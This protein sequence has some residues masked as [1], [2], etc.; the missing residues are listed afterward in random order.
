[1][2]RSRLSNEI[3]QRIR[4]AVQKSGSGKL[5]IDG[6]L[7]ALLLAGSQSVSRREIERLWDLIP[8]LFVGMEAVFGGGEE[9]RG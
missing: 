1:M 3:T 8:R 2:T 6:R 9:I 7:G 5:K 4:L